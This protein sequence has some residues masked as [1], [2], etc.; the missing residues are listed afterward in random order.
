MAE[1][2]ARP[3]EKSTD[4]VDG[5]PN[6]QTRKPDMLAANKSGTAFSESLEWNTVE[7]PMRGISLLNFHVSFCNAM[8]PV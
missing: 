4:R 1:H 7:F 5:Y 2:S 6:R 8:F 3:G